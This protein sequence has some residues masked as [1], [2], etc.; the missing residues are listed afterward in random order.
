MMRSKAILALTMLTL[1]VGT[2]VFAAESPLTL[3]ID[4][5]PASH[6]KTVA[7]LRDGVAY[8]E[9]VTLVRVFGGLV[10]ITKTGVTAT[11]GVHVARFRVHEKKAT[12]DGRQMSM[13][14]ATFKEDGDLY[15][16]LAFFV[17]NVVP[18][19]KLRIDRVNAIASLQVRSP[20]LGVGARSPL[21]SP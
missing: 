13:A 10:T 7:R 5:R 19:T 3:R 8:A 6:D 21:P 1:L 4:G 20:L 15:V 16:P 11:V 18:G 17:K 14:T 2:P 12:I 9:V